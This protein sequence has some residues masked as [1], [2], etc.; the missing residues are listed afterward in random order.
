MISQPALQGLDSRSDWEFWLARTIRQEAPRSDPLIH[1]AVNALKW[2]RHGDGALGRAVGSG[3]TAPAT[4]AG[5][6]SS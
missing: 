4:P 1:L 5:L 2:R 3:P 6:P